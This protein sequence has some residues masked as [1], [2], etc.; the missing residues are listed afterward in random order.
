ML[1]YA[2]VC[3]GSRST[4]FRTEGGRLVKQQGLVAGSTQL[5]TLTLKMKERWLKV[6][7]KVCGTLGGLAHCMRP[8]SFLSLFFFL[9]A[10]GRGVVRRR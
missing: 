6:A 7:G 4:F 1:T 10:D 9:L 2:D 3:S 5:G 8:E